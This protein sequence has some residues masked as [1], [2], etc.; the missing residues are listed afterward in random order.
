MAGGRAVQKQPDASEMNLVTFRE[1]F[2][3]CSRE[4]LHADGEYLKFKDHPELLPSPF[5]RTAKQVAK[6]LKSNP[7]F[8]IQTI[9]C[10]RF[11]GTCKSDNPD[12]QKLRG[13]TCPPK[14]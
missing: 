3:I 10:L 5:H 1:Q 13:F 11:G 12:C 9:A 6:Q 8:G 4:G 14:S 2:C 7:D